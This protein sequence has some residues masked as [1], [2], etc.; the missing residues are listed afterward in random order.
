[1]WP[2]IVPL[3]DG[4]LNAK[5]FTGGKKVL[6]QLQTDFAQDVGQ[7]HGLERG[8]EGSQAKHQTVKEFYAQVNQPIKE[9][10][11]SAQSVEPRVIEKAGIMDKMRGRGD[12][13]ESNKGV[14][15][16]LTAAVQQAYAP[17]IEKAKQG[18][19]QAVERRNGPDG[20]NPCQRQKTAGR[21]S[22][23]PAEAL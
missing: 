15:D 4:K 9:V 21:G 13:V 19:L 1:M 6:S 2:Y 23:G 11:L 17:V 22:T 12:L 7:R 5:H 14:A 16:R 10:Q 20:R 8:I 3:K 18:D